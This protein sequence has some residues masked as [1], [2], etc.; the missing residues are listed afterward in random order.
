MWPDGTFVDF[1]RSLNFAVAELRAALRDDARSPRFIETIPKRGYR[2]IAEVRT[3]EETPAPHADTRVRRWLGIAAALSLAAVQLPFHP[4]AH[5]RKTAAPE[6]RAA[7]DLA[8]TLSAQDDAARRRSIAALRT[9]T[10]IDPRFAEAHYALGEL[11][12]DLATKRELPVDAAMTEARAA[13]ERAVSLEEAAETH[14]LLGTIRL[15]NDWDWRGARHELARAVALDPKWDL[16]FV[17]YARLLSAEGD[18]AA[19]IA[20]IDRAE[21]LSPNCDLIL[22]EAGGIYARAGRYDEAIAKLERA[23]VFGP[24]HDVTA[25]D[26]MRR[27]RSREFMINMARHDWRAAHESATA[28]VVASGAPAAAQQ[29]F[30][31]MDANVAVNA[32]IARSVGASKA[33]RRPA[34]IQLAALEA[35]HG[36]ISSALDSLE[37]AADDRDPELPFALRDPEFAALKAL[38]RF[39]QLVARIRRSA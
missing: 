30:R 2:F 37:R 25:L 26:W 3:M 36:D 14:R 39:R 18:D 33:A 13:A 8:M 16:G 27:V 5:T 6:A 1:D 9:A 28:L 32:F 22:F 15:V 23:I 4:I 34:A 38:P 11:Y 31:A 29:R 21:T 19:A 24:P 12:F 35:I 7:F 17:A 20:A 10:R